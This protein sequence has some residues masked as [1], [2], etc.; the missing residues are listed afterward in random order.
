[1]DTIPLLFTPQFLHTPPHPSPVI[2]FYRTSNL[3]LLQ[4]YLISILHWPYSSLPI[5]CII[6]LCNPYLT[7]ITI[8]SSLFIIPYHYTWAVPPL[9]VL[10][11]LVTRPDSQS[12][13]HF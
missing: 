4:S 13:A 10:L 1:M 6:C 7:I 11:A 3:R 2:H 8:S 9:L 5:A 12:S